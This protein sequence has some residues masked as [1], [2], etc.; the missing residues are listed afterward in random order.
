MR[1]HVVFP[2]AGVYAGLLLPPLRE[3][4]RRLNL[5]VWAELTVGNSFREYRALDAYLRVFGPNIISPAQEAHFLL[6]SEGATIVSCSNDPGG[7]VALR[8]VEEH[9]PGRVYLRIYPRVYHGHAD[10][11]PGAVCGGRTA[12]SAVLGDAGP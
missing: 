9:R 5:A 7:V 3:L 6:N 2:T 10:S 11:D 12:V 8:V 1:Q 4:L